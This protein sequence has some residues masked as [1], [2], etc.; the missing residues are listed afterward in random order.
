MLFRHL[1][2]VMHELFCGRAMMVRDALFAYTLTPLSSYGGDVR[3]QAKGSRG[4]FRCPD[5]LAELRAWVE[6]TEHMPSP[7]NAALADGLRA[8]GAVEQG[9]EE[10][11]D[12]V[13]DT[14]AGA[15]RI[16]LHERWT[17][18]KFRE[19]AR[20]AR[21]TD[22]NPFTGKW[23]FHYDGAPTVGDANDLLGRICRLLEQ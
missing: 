10:H 22:C 21:Y 5:N 20:A 12:F 13:L 9:P 15:L 16:S 4:A 19:P 14:P 6:T 8:F 23:N 11:H 1:C 7:Y 17:H 2:D 3:I 18:T